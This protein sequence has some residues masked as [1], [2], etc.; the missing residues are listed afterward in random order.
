MRFLLQRTPARATTSALR[1]IFLNPPSLSIRHHYPLSSFST[2]RTA[3]PLCNST[4][5]T[6]QN[7]PKEDPP[8]TLQHYDGPAP[9][10]I[11]YTSC[12][13]EANEYLSQLDG[14][15][16]GFDMIWPLVSAE[17]IISLM[18]FCGD[19]LIVLYQRT[20]KYHSML[21]SV[22]VCLIRDPN[23]YKVGLRIKEDYNKLV[24]Y[25]SS[26]YRFEPSSFL[27]LSRLAR[28]VEPEWRGGGKGY[29][30]LEDL[31]ERYLVKGMNRRVT[32]K[33]D[34]WDKELSWKA[35][36]HAAADFTRLSGY[37]LSSYQSQTLKALI[38]TTRPC[39]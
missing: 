35:K 3:Q 15:V 37:T 29:I 32:K 19:R 5:D 14:S 20:D 9:P 11:L 25:L 17:H 39:V 24:E 7:V 6:K 34:N 27:A 23:V 33:R 22:G 8:T 1:D 4:I 28:M 21:P 36:R 18:Q 26:I 10:K 13:Q 12:P 31:C 30:H 16:L 38:S 2:A